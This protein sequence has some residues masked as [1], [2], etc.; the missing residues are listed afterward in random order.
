[1][2]S[3]TFTSDR[4]DLIAALDDL[5]YGNPTRLYDA[6]D[7]SIDLLDEATGRKVVLVFS[8]GDDT[9]SRRSFDDVLEKAREKEVMIYS[10]GLQSEFFNGRGI[11]RSRPP[12]AL[13][14]LA[15]ETGGGFFDL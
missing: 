5:Q 14:R 2:F 8:D 4:D 7:T 9:A 11:M 13:R 3:G 10:I 1:M 15:E 6:I 12:T